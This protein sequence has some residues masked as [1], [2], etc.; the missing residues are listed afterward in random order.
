MNILYIRFCDLHPPILQPYYDTYSSMVHDDPT[1]VLD[2]YRC[3]VNYV[4]EWVF[5][6][7]IICHKRDPRKVQR[8]CF[9]GSPT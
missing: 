2:S 9:I 6:L 1:N 7:A 3:F 5:M 4:R 8:V